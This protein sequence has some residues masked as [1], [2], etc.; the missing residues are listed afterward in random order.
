[1]RRFDVIAF[2]AVL[3]CLSFVVGLRDVPLRPLAP[4]AM[5]PPPPE[6]A[7]ERDGKLEVRV[8]GD[9][10]HPIADA[11]VRVLWEHGGRY[12]LAARAGTDDQGSV[13]LEK[14]PRGASWVLAEARGH[15]RGST[16][17]IV[18][19]EARVLSISLPA[20]HRLAVKVAD[21]HGAPIAEAT[22]LVTTGDPLPYGALSD[23]RGIARFDRLGASPWTVKA[24]AMGY[25]SIT[26]SGVTG[27]VTIELRRLG[28]LEVR[29]ELPNGSPAAGAT[30][31]ISGSALWP[32]RRTET[33]A[34]G[35]VQIAGLLA[36][37]YDL[38]ATLGDLVSPTLY[39]LELARGEHETVTLRLGAGRMVRA[40][41]TDGDEDG[42]PV[43]PNAD[44][45]LAE[46]GL[47]T[48]PLRGRTGTD[49]TV[50][51]GPIGSG[52]ATLAARAPEFVATAAVAVPEK[53]DGPVR[54]A[55]IKG[56]TLLGTVVDTK[57]RP[58]DGASVEV[59]GTDQHGLPIA[60]TP[61]LLAFRRTHFEWAL[62]GPS[63]LI[64]AGELGVMP[65][66]VPPIPP[67]GAVIVPGGVAAAVPLPA[68]SEPE[69]E[70]EPWVTRW[71]GTFTARPVTPGRVRAIVRHPAYVEG[72]SDVVAL[73][74]GGEAKVKV[75]MRAGG[76]IEGKVVDERGRAVEGVR[77][78]LTAVRGTMERTT[79]TASDGTFA[80]AAVPEEVL[81]S[82]ARP[83]D[84]S[85]IVLRKSVEV[86][87]EK[88]T[89]VE[90]TLP[91]ERE[92]V[93]V[94]VVADRAPVDA[95][96][97]T[98]LSLDPAAPFRQTLFTG[99]EGTVE[100]GDARGLDLRVVVEAPG[101]TRAVQT[102]DRAPAEITIELSR[103]VIVTGRVTAIRGRKYLSGASVTLVGDGRRAGAL[104]DGEGR[105]SLADVAPG[106]ARLIVSHPEFAKAE[107]DV[108]IE[109]TAR[110]D[111][112]FE[113]ADVDLPEPSAIE[114]EVVDPAGRPVS[115]A[116]VAAGVVPA[117]LPAGALPEGMAVTDRKGRFRLAG[118]APGK[119]DLE[120]YAP[121]VGRGATRGVEVTSGRATSGVR[122]KLV[123]GTAD[124]DPAAQASVAVTLGERGSGD[125]IEI[126]VVHVAAGSEAE[127]AGIRSGDLVLAVDGVDVW[128]MSDARARLSGPN[129]TDVVI[130]LDRDGA[131]VRLR[132][133]R[134]AVRR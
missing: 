81:L 2:L 101:F 110:A 27:D 1:M 24:S 122:I 70:I 42:A 131:S 94:K 21:D 39:A 88:T 132:V 116:R 45:V 22:V 106:P 9:D 60:E 134:E 31:L 61:T 107:L 90:I 126:V 63:P 8:V 30:I 41:V 49:G 37:T 13:A 15:A 123:A 104:T 112:P 28:S 127:R 10:G 59:V 118:V 87:E 114:G 115:G 17:V 23:A 76:S 16:Q 26:R 6:D 109:R 29:V 19:E 111:R 33:D 46:A 71:D 58:I 7:G 85:R 124:D 79:M 48:F 105:F 75:V 129:G 113:L 64:P 98:L 52:P 44:V 68:P 69:P 102:F 51:L 91:G 4:T 89:R 11:T 117:Y 92:G 18:D 95:A 97:V 62:S 54:V 55:L 67:P 72:L 125:A 38:R 99:S 100:I 74:P 80:F 5:A 47:S 43:V 96:Q 119:V 25:E 35:S 128:S 77:V 82:F 130:E 32:A 50:L 36:G 133:A 53:L 34:R 14:L 66:P 20:A 3:T 93:R 65:G 84:P 12:Y 57:D 78:D 83:E 103:G 120:A 40:L 73:A 108:T 121:D 86:E 56:G